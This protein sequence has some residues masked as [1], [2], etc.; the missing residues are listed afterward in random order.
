MKSHIAFLNAPAYG[1]IYAT[2]P[3]VEELVNRGHRV[4]YVVTEKF[5]DVVRAAGASAIEYSSL[6]T[7]V[8][9]SRLDPISV[10]SGSLDQRMMIF[11]EEA[12]NK[13]PTLEAHFA[14]DPPDLVAYD[15][16]MRLQGP[17][18]ARSF[19]VPSMQLLP[20]FASNDSF[21]FDKCILD[22]MGVSQDHPEWVAYAEKVAEFFAER[23]VTGELVEK[24]H[25]RVRRLQPRVLS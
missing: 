10:D 8:F 11:L 12:I 19:G 4:S 20:I 1:H 22:S 14:S 25:G 16:L 18:L 17:L 9:A 7:S 6:L 21:S 5:V 15:M 2:L 24:I 13:L 3:V 23:G